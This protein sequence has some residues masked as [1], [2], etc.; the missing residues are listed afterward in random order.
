M[1]ILCRLL[2]H[3]ILR[4]DS[5]AAFTAG[6]SI[7]TSTPIMAITTSNSTSVKPAARSRGVRFIALL[8]KKAIGGRKCRN[9]N[10]S[11]PANQHDTLIALRDHPQRQAAYAFESIATALQGQRF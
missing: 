7:E 5:R 10:S 1:T 8:R 9:G 6:S 11:W 2:L 4:A 3:C